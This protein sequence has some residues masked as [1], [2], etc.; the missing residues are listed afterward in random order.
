MKKTIA[1]ILCLTVVA[2]GTA[3]ATYMAADS[4][5]KIDN[6]TFGPAALQV[7]VG[8]KV[9]W[10][11]RDDIPHTIVDA[12]MQRAFKSGPLDSNESFSYVF[13]KAGTYHYFCSLHPRMQGTV[14]VQ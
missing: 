11:N 14:V 9:V 12:A 5:V 8:T 7:R 3:S 13:A 1:R 4:G 2:A 10:T 6:F